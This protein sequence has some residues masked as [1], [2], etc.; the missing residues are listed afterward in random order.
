MTDC[1]HFRTRT[2]ANRRHEC[3]NQHAWNVC[4]RN[5]ATK[6]SVAFASNHTQVKAYGI[7]VSVAYPPDTDT[8]G[9]K[10]E[11]V[12]KPD[13]TKLM[14]EGG[15]MYSPAQASFSLLQDTSEL[16]YKPAA[17]NASVDG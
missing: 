15:G 16:L 1:K 12:G 4:A 14:E 11:N 5:S 2:K 8:P 13:A 6:F 9:F 17:E 10:V 3:R 7:G